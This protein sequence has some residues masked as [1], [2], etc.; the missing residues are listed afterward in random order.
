MAFL[1]E[2]KCGRGIFRQLS[3][4]PQ[5]PTLFFLCAALLAGCSDD[6]TAS[7]D[8]G[9]VTKADKGVPKTCTGKFKIEDL[10]GKPTTET[11][12]KSFIFDQGKF[13]AY[14][15]EVA[16]SDWDWLQKNALKEEYVPAKV[17]FE[18]KRYYGAAVRYKGDWT[19]LKMCFDTTGKLTCPKLSLKVRFNKYDPCGRFHGMRRIMFNSSRT[20]SSFM[21]ERAAW[22]L[23]KDVGMRGSQ[24]T[25]AT[26]TVNS[27][28]QGVFVMVEQVDKEFLE[29]HFTNPEGNL[30]KQAWPM[31]SDPKV[32]TAALK[33]N[34]DDNPSVTRMV[35]FAAAL[36]KT[37]AASAAKDLAPFIDLKRLA[38][39]L[40][41]H[42]SIGNYDGPFT[43]RCW[44]A[45][46]LNNNFYF[47]DEP[48]GNIA[49]LPWDLDNIISIV[50]PDLSADFWTKK[51]SSCAADEPCKFFGTK[52]C[53]PTTPST[54]KIIPTA[55]DPLLNYAVA[56][57]KA[58]YRAMMTKLPAALTKAQANLDTWFA[59]IKDAMAADKNGPGLTKFTSRVKG[60]KSLLKDR[61]DQITAYLAKT[62]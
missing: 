24:A 33:T 43:F 38:G 35:Q 57:N 16:S 50:P 61:A 55:C 49:M 47:Y 21:R 19:S 17:V 37:T 56:T 31:H 11:T 60:V 58:A 62:K 1:C 23:M 59:Q 30:Y 12:G 54:Y 39:E 27:T 45:W 28:S 3:C 2:M 53:P 26:L 4:L 22:N 7:T 18:G 8:D 48:Q 15:L 20:D 34:E 40:A 29:D 41:V 25:H 51:P 36:K 10:A 13:H 32:Y 6:R 5:P 46:C 14:K 44:D 52:P 42:L 9:A